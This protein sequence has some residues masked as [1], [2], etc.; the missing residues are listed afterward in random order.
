MIRTGLKINMPT[1][2]VINPNS[3]EAVTAAIDEAL[4]PLRSNDGPEI[5]CV[6]LTEGPPGIESQRDVDSVV[7]PLLKRAAALENHAAAFVI[8]CFSDPGVSLRMPISARATPCGRTAV[9]PRMTIEKG[10]S[11]IA[12]P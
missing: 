3:T 6:T 12:S 1:I 4:E 8:A 9:P 11:V 5:E 7:A 2:Y 10:S